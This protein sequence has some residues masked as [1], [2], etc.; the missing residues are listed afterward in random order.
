MRS[1]I[2]EGMDGSGKD[3]LIASLLRT[4]SGHTLHARA[5]TSIG[6]P[7]RNL[8]EWV[9]HDATTMR[10]TGPWI[11]NRHPLV[12]ET[13]YAPY[14]P[15]KPL[16]PGFENMPWLD[17]YRRIV[18]A[19]SVMVICQPPYERVAGNLIASG[20]RAHMPGVFDNR[21]SIYTDYAAFSWP[22]R[23]IRYDYT[24]DT[25]ADLVTALSYQLEN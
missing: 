23:T 9:R 17:A 16:S 25:V 20:A 5:S 19:S 12:S 3:T 13:I 7:V 4:Y 21:M 8:A 1:I 18:S 2:V 14:R 11:Y 10:E 15:S 22:G 6:G 24:R